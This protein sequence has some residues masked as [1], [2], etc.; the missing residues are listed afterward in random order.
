[1][2]KMA[3]WWKKRSIVEIWIYKMKTSGKMFLTDAL[4]LI[5]EAIELYQ[6]GKTAP[7]SINILMQVKKE[8]E[9][10]IRVMNPKIYSPSYPRFIIDWPGES[11]IMSKLINAAYYYQKIRK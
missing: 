1:M 11:E 2:M 8:L 6:D 10:M 7:L 5:L 3:E 4:Q 9:E